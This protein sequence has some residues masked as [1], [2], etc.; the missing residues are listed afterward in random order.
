MKLTFEF[1]YDDWFL[2]ETALRH[3]INTLNENI[4]CYNRLV[5]IRDKINKTLKE[6]F[7][8]SKEH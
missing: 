7:F 8:Q 3:E 6:I 2:I 4:A 1:D 5:S